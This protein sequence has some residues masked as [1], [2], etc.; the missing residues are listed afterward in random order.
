VERPDP[1]LG[2]DAYKASSDSHGSVK[3]L[4][5]SLLTSAPSFIKIEEIVVATHYYE[6]LKYP[7]H[8]NQPT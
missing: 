8:T 7:K 4:L 5:I 6:N 3:A 1:F 2:P